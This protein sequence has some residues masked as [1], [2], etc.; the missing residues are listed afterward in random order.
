MEG[1]KKYSVRAVGEFRTA[2]EIINLP[3]PGTPLTLSDVADVR[4]DYPEENSFQHL[5]GVDAVTVRIM[6]ASN[7]NIVETADG[8]KAVM[9]TLK[10]EPQ[11]AALQ[12]RV[13]FDQSKDIP[14]GV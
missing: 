1:G 7:A 3:I 13:F 11:F 8:V 4:Y 14:L 9:E 6:K 10:E 5:N 2:D 12:T